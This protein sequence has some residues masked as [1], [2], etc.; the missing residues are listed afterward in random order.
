MCILLFY[1]DEPMP[2]IWETEGDENEDEDDDEEEME[3]EIDWV[4]AEECATA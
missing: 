4:D 1:L 3:H 2:T